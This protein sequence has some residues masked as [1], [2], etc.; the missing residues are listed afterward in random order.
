MDI[1][2]P[3]VVF[4]LTLQDNVLDTRKTV[5]NFFLHLDVAE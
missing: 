4:V 1:A 5:I 2:A 3:S